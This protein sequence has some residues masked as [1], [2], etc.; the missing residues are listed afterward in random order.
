MTQG[1]IRR[2]FRCALLA[3][4]APT[5]VE[6][7]SFRALLAGQR[8]PLCHFVRIRR[9]DVEVELRSVFRMKSHEPV[10][11]HDTLE[12]DQVPQD[13]MTRMHTFEQVLPQARPRLRHTQG[14]HVLGNYA[15][16]RRVTGTR[17]QRRN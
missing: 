9:D 5:L 1:L 8:K 7:R 6:A 12:Q 14:H 15:D 10:L 3:T 4:Q 17:P 13:L 11:A 2:E 16:T